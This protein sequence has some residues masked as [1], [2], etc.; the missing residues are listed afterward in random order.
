M[1]SIQDKELEKVIIKSV[2][3][4]MGEGA[5]DIYSKL[6]SENRNMLLEHTSYYFSEIMLEM[7]AAGYITEEEY[8]K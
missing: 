2:P 8:G 5:Y 6:T 3:L 1:S 7:M 4:S